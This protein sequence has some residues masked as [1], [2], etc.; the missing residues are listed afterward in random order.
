MD[1][2]K[3]ILLIV[4]LYCGVNG[5]DSNNNSMQSSPNTTV[6]LQGNNISS[7]GRNDSDHLAEHD[8]NQVMQ[9]CNESYQIQMSNES[10]KGCLFIKSIRKFFAFFA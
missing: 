3:V 2:F 10:T 4:H 1:R 9:K 8:L 7:S 5:M 6:M